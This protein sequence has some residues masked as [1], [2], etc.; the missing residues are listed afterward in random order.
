MFGSARFRFSI[1]VIMERLYRRLTLNR[2]ICRIT[3]AESLGYPKWGRGIDTVGNGKIE[4]I[5]AS[6]MIS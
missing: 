4:G 6:G 2:K 1:R 5:S 3:G